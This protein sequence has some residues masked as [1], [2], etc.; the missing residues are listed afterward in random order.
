[1]LE[2]LQS[3]VMQVT[4]NRVAYHEKHVVHLMYKARGLE[5]VTDAKLI[6]NLIE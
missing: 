5:K 1:M 3:L 2:W 6:E 4:Q